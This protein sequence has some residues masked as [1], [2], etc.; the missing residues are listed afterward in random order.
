MKQAAN[1]DISLPMVLPR[2]EVKTGALDYYGIK[3]PCMMRFNGKTWELFRDLI[4]EN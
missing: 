4:G 2:I 1:L 3:T